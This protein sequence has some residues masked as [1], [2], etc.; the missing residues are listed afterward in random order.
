M[1]NTINNK[2]AC[3]K[4]KTHGFF[5]SWVGVILSVVGC[6]G[7]KMSYCVYQENVTCAQGQPVDGACP[8]GLIRIES[9]KEMPGCPV[10]L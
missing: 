5:A 1:E 3:V 7:K 9:E 10:S 2:E 8:L 6:G 4:K